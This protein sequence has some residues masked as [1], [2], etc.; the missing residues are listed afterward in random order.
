MLYTSK[1]YAHFSAEGLLAG[2][3]QPLTATVSWIAAALDAAAATP[4]VRSAVVQSVPLVGAS[5]HAPESDP[6]HVLVHPQTAR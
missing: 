3:G 2:A 4:A 5:V 6:E 1:L